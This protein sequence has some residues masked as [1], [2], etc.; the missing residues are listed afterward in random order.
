MKFGQL[1][2]LT[3]PYILDTTPSN[4][5]DVKLILNQLQDVIKYSNAINSIHDMFI[6]K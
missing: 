4:V 1:N 2:L 3:F 6:A 5:M